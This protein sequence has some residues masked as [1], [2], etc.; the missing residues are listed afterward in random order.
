MW[1][2][3]KDY[4]IDNSKECQNFCRTPVAF[5]RWESNSCP[6]N[7][8][9][10]VKLMVSSVLSSITSFQPGAKLSQECGGLRF[11]TNL[12]LTHWSDAEQLASK[13]NLGS[14]GYTKTVAAEAEGVNAAEYLTEVT[15]ILGNCWEPEPSGTSL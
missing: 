11:S 13:L 15:V 10:Q 7:I 3:Q 6:F 8:N 5:R 9:I 2:I 4:K 14:L 1:S 12:Q